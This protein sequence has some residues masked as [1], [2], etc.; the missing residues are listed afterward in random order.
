MDTLFTGRNIIELAECPS[1]N[2]HAIELLKSSKLTEGTVIFT[3]SK[4]LEEGSE[5]ILGLQRK[6]K[7]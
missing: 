6:E 4:P 2:T 5:V 3:K 1:V 7:I